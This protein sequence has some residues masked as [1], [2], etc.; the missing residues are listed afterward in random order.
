VRK[1]FQNPLAELAK[2]R[3]IRSLTQV[4]M[5]SLSTRTV[6]YKGLLLAGQVGSFYKDLRDERCESALALVHQRFSTNTFPSWKLA[7]PYRFIAHNGEINTVRGNVNWMN[8]RRRSL[9]SDLLGPTS[10]RCG[11]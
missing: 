7:H 8:A 2:K 6:V 1:Q 3:G 4:Y 5:P 11:R 9:E 10:T